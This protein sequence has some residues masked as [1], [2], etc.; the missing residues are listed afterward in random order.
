MKYIMLYFTKAAFIL[1]ILI[2][3]RELCIR[4]VAVFSEK[5]KK[6]NKTF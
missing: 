5:S 6:K 1:K 3:H 2:R 4:R